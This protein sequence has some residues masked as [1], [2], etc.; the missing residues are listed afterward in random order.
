[1]RERTDTVAVTGDQSAKYASYITAAAILALVAIRV[2][3]ERK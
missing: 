1:M 3:M 2:L